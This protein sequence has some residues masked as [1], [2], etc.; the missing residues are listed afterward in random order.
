MS[1][2][3]ELN[4]LAVQYKNCSTQGDRIRLQ[5]K[6]Y[7]LTMPYLK[8]YFNNK[9]FTSFNVGA[10]E[11]NDLA[12]ITISK[13]FENFD[14]Y[15]SEFSFSTW[16]SNIAK[17]V[18]IDEIRS[19]KHKKQRNTTQFSK[20][21]VSDED[22][23]T[24]AIGYVDRKSVFKNNDE[25]I[26]SENFEELASNL[27]EKIKNPTQREALKLYSSGVK[28]KDIAEKLE[29]DM[30]TIKQA[31][32]MARKNFLKLCKGTLLEGRANSTKN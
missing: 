5:N 32:F 16:I 9:F 13:I 26:V 14:T 15:D 3:K 1:R 29:K 4:L 23:T 8:S 17:N 31:I 25:N 7:S 6:I 2:F 18:L 24:D 11:A 30:T 21:I 28:Y 19:K 12:N 10:V 20:I 27:I 22:K